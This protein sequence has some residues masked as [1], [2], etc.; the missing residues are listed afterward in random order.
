MKYLIKYVA[1]TC[2]FVENNPQINITAMVKKYAKVWLRVLVYDCEWKY[3]TS[4]TLINGR[5]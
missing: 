4:L 5:H 1:F 2:G 3:I